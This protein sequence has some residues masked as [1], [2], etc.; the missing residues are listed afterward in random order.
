MTWARLLLRHLRLSGTRWGVLAG[1]VALASALTML[2]PRWLDTTTTHE[3]RS[4]LGSASRIFV[5][6]A[7]APR[8][9]ILLPPPD[10]A[11]GRW[12]SQDAWRVVD[13]ALTRDRA[14]LPEP[15]RGLLGAPQYQLT[16]Q[17][18]SARDASV[19]DRGLMYVQPANAPQL[20]EHVRI[21]EGR[22]P[23][24]EPPAVDGVDRLEVA[25]SVESADQMRWKVGDVRG[26]QLEDAEGLPVDV[27]LV[28]T[29]TPDDPHSSY[30][31]NAAT[32]LHPTFSGTNDTGLIVGVRGLISP[33][34]GLR[35]M[36]A[37]LPAI[38]PDS[39][40]LWFPL[41]TDHLEAR[42]AATVAHQL[43][44]E[45]RGVSDGGGTVTFTS[46][47]PEHIDT[48][49]ARARTATTV[50]GIAVAAPAG[51]LLALLAL[52]AQV[53][54]AP[55][56][57]AQRLVALRGGTVAQHRALLGTEAALVSLPAAALGG[58]AAQALIPVDVSPW[59]W[60][61]PGLLGLAPVAALGTGSPTPRSAA[62]P[63]VAV[64]V[65]LTLLAAAAV[66]ELVV[67][68][69]GAA[70]ANPLAVLAPLLLAVLVALACVRLVPRLLAP[71][72]RRL[73]DRDDLVDP[74]GAALA[75]R[76]T[77][78][79]TATVATVAGTA[80][81]LLGVLVTSTIDAART[82]AARADVGADVRV[83]G[84]LDGDQ[85]EALRTLP[86]VAAVAP[87]ETS[88]SVAVQSGD[89]HLLVPLYAV[90]PE[91][92]VVQRD[93]PG[94]VPVPPVGGLIASSE[95]RRHSGDAVVLETAPHVPLTVTA[96]ATAAPGL[97]GSQRWIVVNRASLVDV[98]T[99]LD[100]TRAFL[101]LEP[102][103]DPEAVAAAVR[104]V[105]GPAATVDAAHTRLE[106]LRSAATATAMSVGIG[107]VVAAGLLAAMLAVALALADRSARRT[108][109]VAVLRTMGLPS[110][111]EVRLVLWEVAPVVAVSVLAGV[112]LGF[113]LTGLLLASTD[114][115]PFTGGAAQPGLVVDPVALTG[116]VVA[117]VA[118]ACVAVAVSAFAAARRSAAVVLRAGEDR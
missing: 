2:W 10:G 55:R 60:L 34:A 45:L 65:G 48:V 3:L 39:T 96:T 15:L 28:G 81:A 8:A 104:D 111:A 30:W 31:Q 97:T 16:W 25:M 14:S 109:V 32:L 51:V 24:Q 44:T 26:A 71:L 33:G 94:A 83:T 105:A 56:R 52:A 107:V 75:A 41:R 58:L 18:L 61:A 73:R 80:V 7:A 99:H 40:R 101:A 59:W 20:L 22:A 19:P 35:T 37:L 91:L 68:G 79:L 23:A 110:R 66:I 90:G 82:D 102:S 6:P 63:R 29:F 77:A 9:V 106:Q 93:V 108:R 69:P 67:T 1:V 76:R 87:V 117:V 27:V 50:L 12:T 11:A 21:V 72:A 95:T 70:G 74:L 38:A 115:R 112:G 84:Y 118:V 92:A 78:P 57:T 43:R 47:A 98:T 49:L 64:E 53:V 85:V 4:D 114:V 5:D 17:G 100:V 13:A 54:V 36:S 116:A 89:S 88:T 62:A 113:A 86:G 103:A 46:N 42:E